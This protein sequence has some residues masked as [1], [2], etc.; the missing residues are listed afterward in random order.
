MVTSSKNSISRDQKHGKLQAEAGIA[1][2]QEVRLSHHTGRTA[3][4]ATLTTHLL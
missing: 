4:R 3:A 2:L 1:K